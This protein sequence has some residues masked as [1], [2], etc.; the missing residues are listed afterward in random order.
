MESGHH[1]S[2]ATVA[3]LYKTEYQGYKAAVEGRF[4]RLFDLRAD[5]SPRHRL[6]RLGRTDGPMDEQTA[7]DV[8]GDS[9]VPAGLRGLGITFITVGLISLC[10]MSFGGIDI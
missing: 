10:F 7:Q 6:V 4:C 3:D 8:I 2:H 1:G 5:S 9:D